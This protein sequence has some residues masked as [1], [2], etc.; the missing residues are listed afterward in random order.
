MKPAI[1]VG[2]S[3]EV[4]I[5]VTAAMQAQF[6]QEVV[7]SL[8]S[9]ATLVNHMEWAARKAILPYLDEHEE[10]MGSMVEVH[11]LLP[12]LTN[13]QVKVIATISNIKDK[14]VECEVEAF[15]SRG[16]IGKG[17]I[18]QAIV[19]KK[20]LQNKIAEISVVEHIKA[21]QQSSNLR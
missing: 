9:T 17:R 16:K 5:I 11:H 4:E 13:M 7:H 1:K 19:D 20:W 18:V 2:Q 3:A 12:T 14:K 21:D 10:A 6:N 15:N 8:Y